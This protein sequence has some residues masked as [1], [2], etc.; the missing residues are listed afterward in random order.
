MRKGSGAGLRP[1][2]DDSAL[3]IGLQELRRRFAEAAVDLDPDDAD[4]GHA[5]G[6]RERGREAVKHPVGLTAAP[7]KHVRAPYVAESPI[8]FECTLNQ[9]VTIS[10]APGGASLVLGTVVHMHFDETVWREGNHIDL[11]AYQPVG[12]LTGS[13]YSRVNDFIEIHRFPSEIG[14]KD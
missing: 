13:L 2:D 5:G 8:H 10:D 11:E 7:A 14:Q 3:G 1:D 9:I 12:R 4:G 6:G